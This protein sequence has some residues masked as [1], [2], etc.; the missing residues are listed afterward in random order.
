V[1]SIIIWNNSNQKREDLNM[2]KFK[3][4]NNNNNNNN[5]NENFKIIQSSQ[6]NIPTQEK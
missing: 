6:Q 4:V 1:A 5:N 2:K 3:I